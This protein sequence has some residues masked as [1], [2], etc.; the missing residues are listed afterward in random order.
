MKQR[1]DTATRCLLTY[2][3]RERIVSSLFSLPPSFFFLFT[4]GEARNENFM[5][6]VSADGETRGEI[7]EA[8][9]AE[10]QLLRAGSKSWIHIVM[11]MLRHDAYSSYSLTARKGLSLNDPRASSACSRNDHAYIHERHEKRDLFSRVNESA[12]PSNVIQGT[13]SWADED[14]RCENVIYISSIG[15]SRHGT[16]N[17]ARYPLE[18]RLFQR[19]FSPRAGKVNSHRIA[20]FTSRR[21]DHV[22]TISVPRGRR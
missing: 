22:G 4:H 12:V 2:V 8:P 5:N 18:I 1:A 11:I 7:G 16:W 15:V 6:R 20:R 17:V 9:R 19:R 14:F 21:S 10:T 13:S 3:Q